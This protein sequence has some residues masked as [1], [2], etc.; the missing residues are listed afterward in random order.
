MVM[1]V[2]TMKMTMMM[3]MLRMRAL[4]LFLKH[5]LLL[6]HY[7]SSQCTN[8]A[9]PAIAKMTIKRLTIW[10]KC[11][12]MRVALECWLLGLLE[13]VVVRSQERVQEGVETR[14]GREGK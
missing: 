11:A 7:T 13:E 8:I 14:E 12:A 4:L 10:S 3:M 6:L 1:M 9:H 5:L 2:L